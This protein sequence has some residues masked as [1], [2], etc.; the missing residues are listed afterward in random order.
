MRPASRAC[1]DDTEMSIVDLNVTTHM[2]QRPPTVF[3]HRG[4]SG[5]RPE[6]T[7]AAYELAI[8]QCADVIEPDVV[9][10]SDG[11]LIARHE[12]EI[13]GTTDVATKTEFAS[14]RTTK[15]VDG[16]GVT[17]WFTED[18]TLAELRTLRAVER[19]PQIRPA[20]TAYDGLYRIP[21]LAEVF[22]LARRSRTCAGQPVGVAP[23][24]KHP[25]Y[26]A[27]LGLA[28][29]EP[30]VAELAN[31]GLNRPSDRVV[32]QSFEVG[33]LQRLNRLTNVRLVQLIDCAGAPYDLRAA[34]DP[35]TYADLVTR[36]GLQGI[37]RYA[38]QIGLC[39]DR[40]IPCDAA[41]FLLEPTNVI[42]DAHDA[43]LTVVGWTFRREN[44]FLPTDYRSSTG[45]AGIGDLAAEITR[46]LDAGMDAFFTD[47]PDIGDHVVRRR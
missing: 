43:G 1:P 6:H 32:I 21:T 22:E 28:L 39:K 37:A 16:V 7:L 10:T 42:P 33:N 11:M 14:R 46:F 18:F 3:A 26:F 8:R 30:L 38:D 20:N 23:E 24:T 2:G 17:G 34:G 9:S 31:A 5:Y 36:S 25:T 15:T 40:M 12:N 4:A 29:E 44:S 47:N 19:L 27:G 35:R 41:G 45:P 13:S